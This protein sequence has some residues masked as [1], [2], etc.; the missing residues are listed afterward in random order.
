MERWAAVCGGD[1]VCTY[2]LCG[3]PP[4]ALEGARAQVQG[5]RAIAYHAGTILCASGWGDTL[6]R[7][8]ARTLAP[9]HVLPL[10]PGVCRIIGAKEPELIY[11]LC[12]DADSVMTF[13][14]ASGQPLML[15]RTGVQPRDMALDAGGERLLIAGGAACEAQVFSAPSLQLITRVETPGLCAGAAWMQERLWTLSMTEQAMG[16]LCVHGAQ[17][18]VRGSI[19]IPALPGGLYADENSMWT[20]Y[21]GGAAQLDAQ[22]GVERSLRLDGLTERAAAV[23][24]GVIFCQ[25][26]TP[27]CLLVTGRGAQTLRGG[28]DVC[29][30][31]TA[32]P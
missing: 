1:E 31:E 5:A 30:Y 10:G 16:M 22:G 2:R 25:P 18:R 11:V 32:A 28:S 17:G 26:S 8:D 27:R 6:W 12:E 4:V 9:L 19:P 23:P 3:M 14:L 7:L 21:W 29:V 13:S 20:M 24:G 15:A